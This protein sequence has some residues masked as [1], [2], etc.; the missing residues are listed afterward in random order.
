M[1]ARMLLDVDL[2]GCDYYLGKPTSLIFPG[3]RDANPGPDS[4]GIRKAA[5]LPESPLAPEMAAPRNP[6]PPGV[7]STVDEAYRIF[8]NEFSELPR[9]EA[10]CLDCIDPSSFAVD[11]PSKVTSHGILKDTSSGVQ[12]I[13]NPLN[14]NCTRPN[15][16]LQEHQSALIA[17]SSTSNPSTHRSPSWS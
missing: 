16:A 9:H 11:C 13:I 12:L 7:C 1:S 15:L 14:R 17:Q 10:S 6:E 5:R 8:V 4:T 3:Y 2:C